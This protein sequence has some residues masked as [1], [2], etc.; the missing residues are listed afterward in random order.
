MTHCSFY[1][2]TQRKSERMQHF[3]M[4]ENVKNKTKQNC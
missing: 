2:L 4:S 1:D 3:N